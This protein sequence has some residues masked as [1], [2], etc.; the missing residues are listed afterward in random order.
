MEPLFHTVDRH[1][2]LDDVNQTVNDTDNGNSHTQFLKPVTGVTQQVTTS[3]GEALHFGIVNDS[4]ITDPDIG[5]CPNGLTVSF[6][7]RLWKTRP[8]FPQPLKILGFG[9]T[10]DDKRG[11]LVMERNDE[12]VIR[13][14]TSRFKCETSF[15]IIS[16]SWTH[17]VFTFHGLVHLKAY[18]NGEG[19]VLSVCTN[20]SYTDMEQ[21]LPS[22]SADAMIEDL[23]FWYRELGKD[24]ISSMLRYIIGKVT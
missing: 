9:E 2:S 14:I 1:W 13:V 3:L 6:W 10:S 20:G 4:C 12:I 19:P 22:G 17:I 18:H 21:S 16:G 23:T 8:S 24:T 11:F 7:L 5:T 15:N